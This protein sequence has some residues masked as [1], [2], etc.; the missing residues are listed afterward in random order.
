MIVRLIIDFRWS[1]PSV[2]ASLWPKG[3]ENEDKDED[4][5]EDEDEELPFSYIITS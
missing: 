3:D 4:E 5:D 1:S 2:S